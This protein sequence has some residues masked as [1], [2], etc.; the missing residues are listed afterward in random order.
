MIRLGSMFAGIGGLCGGLCAATGAEVAWHVEYDPFC[1]AVLE[2]VRPG[3]LCYADTF[4]VE[5]EFAPE[6][7]W[8][9]AGF[10]CQPVSHSGKRKG[11]DDARWLWPEVER[12]ARA[13]RPRLVV[14][15]NVPGVFTANGGAAFRDVLGGLAALRYDAEWGCL[16][17]AGVGA[18][19]LRNRAFVVAWDTLAHA[20]VGKGWKRHHAD[21]QRGRA[22]DPQQAGVGGSGGTNPM[23]HATGERER[24]QATAAH[25]LAARGHAR[26]ESRGGGEPLAHAD[27]EGRLQQGG[28]LGAQRGRAS[29]RSSVASPLGDVGDGDRA[30]LEGRRLP[31]RQRGDERTT[32][33]PSSAGAARAPGPVEPGVGRAAHGVPEGLHGALERG[34]LDAGPWPAG[35]GQAQ[36]AWEAP[37]TA[38]KVPGRSRRLKALGNGVVPA[39]AVE[40]GFAALR[41]ARRE[42]LLL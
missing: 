12:A 1:R 23:A 2:K 20:D 5:Y 14:L 3:V 30:G 10:P 35:R 36:H 21:V 15:E 39:V 4:S 29:N 40:V 19:H 27:S 22:Q 7:D 26:P 24:E 18:P 37:R 31:E 28:A 42:G 16:P 32:W 8:L 17:A 11:V 33:P 9:C 38:H 6:I 13:L 34:A 25:T 41:I